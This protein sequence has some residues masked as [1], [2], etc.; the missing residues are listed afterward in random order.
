ME[1]DTWRDRLIEG[2]PVFVFL[3]IVVIA[4]TVLFWKNS[5][6]DKKRKKALRDLEKATGDLK[7]YIEEHPQNLSSPFGQF[8]SR[9][10]VECRVKC[11]EGYRGVG[12]A[13]YPNYDSALHPTEGLVVTPD[14][15]QWQK[16]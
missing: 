14:A 8:L 5:S 15:R 6:D 16:R 7:K 11:K 10:V 12:D 3:L 9:R 4:G 1:H 13:P 2:L